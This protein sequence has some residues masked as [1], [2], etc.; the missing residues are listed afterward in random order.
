MNNNNSSA[1][2]LLGINFAD[3]KKKNCL[4]LQPAA[5][6]RFDF[7]ELIFYNL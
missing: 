5:K 1:G 3:L 6:Q 2:I 7:N 4:R